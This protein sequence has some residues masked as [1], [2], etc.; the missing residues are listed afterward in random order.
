MIERLIEPI[1]KTIEEHDEPKLWNRGFEKIVKIKK[2]QTNNVF[3]VTVQV[4]TFEGAHNPPYG[5]ETIT[6]QIR[7]NEI[8]VSNYQHREIP[9]AEWSKLE[10]R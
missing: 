6:F 10:L 5:E 7:G 3:Y 8:N 1:S 4:Q 2:D 9:E